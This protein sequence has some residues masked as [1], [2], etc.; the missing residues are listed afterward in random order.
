M[1][2]NKIN[3]GVNESDKCESCTCINAM[4][5]IIFVIQLLFLTGAIT[6]WTS[7]YTKDLI[8]LIPQIKSSITEMSNITK[9]VQSSLPTIRDIVYVGRYLEHNIQKINECVNKYC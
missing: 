8:S 3:D 2:Y 9:G 7:D 1:Y 4:M 6:I 5:C